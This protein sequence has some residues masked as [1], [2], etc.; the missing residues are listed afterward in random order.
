[1]PVYLSHGSAQEVWRRKNSTTLRSSKVESP[2][3]V[4]PLH[5]K[6][7]LE[8]AGVLLSPE[9]SR[10]SRPIDLLVP[11][12]KARIRDT[13]IRNHVWS[14]KLP[15][16]SFARLNDDVLVSTP[17]F[18]YLQMACEL[19]PTRLSCYACELCGAYSLDKSSRS[20]SKHAPLTTI[21]HI[22][23]FLDQLPARTRGLALARKGLSCAVDGIRSPGEAGVLQL[24]CNQHRNGAYG[25]GLPRSNAKIHLPDHWARLLGTPYLVVDFLWERIKLILEYD[26]DLAHTLGIARDHDD[27]RKAALEELGYTVVSLRSARLMDIKRFDELVRYRIAPLLDAKI[28]GY[29]PSFIQKQNDLRAQLFQSRTNRR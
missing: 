25:L 17:P 15:P 5:T 14:T 1:M 7:Q 8:E 11:N 12:A 18:T 4:D 20:F 3:I 27:D 10:L 6:R 22:Q 13:R 9:L 19:T 24:L 26:S 16:G 28:P 29:S 21:E 2:V 23:A